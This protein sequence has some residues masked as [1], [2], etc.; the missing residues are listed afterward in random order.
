MSRFADLVE[1]MSSFLCV[2]LVSKDTCF[3]AQTENESVI[4]SRKMTITS[5][6]KSKRRKQDLAEQGEKQLGQ[7]MIQV[8]DWSACWSA[9][10]HRQRRISIIVYLSHLIQ[11]F[12]KSQGKN[13]TSIKDESRRAIKKSH[14]AKSPNKVS[15]AGESTL[16]EE[17]NGFHRIAAWHA[18]CHLST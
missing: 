11:G 17:L 7:Q 2:R 4:R 14:S 8:A 5:Q 10:L 12:K 3:D 9:V 16:G 18:G 15:S 13:E 6:I 1:S